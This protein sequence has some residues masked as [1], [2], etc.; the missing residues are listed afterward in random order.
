MEVG[1]VSLDRALMRALLF[2]IA[3]LVV[4]CSKPSDAPLVGAS[5]PALLVPNWYVDPANASGCASDANN[6]QSATCGASGVGPLLDLATIVARWGTRTPVLTG[7]VTITIVSDVPA[8]DPWT[9]TPTHAGG[10]LR[11]QGVPSVVATATLG[12]YVAA[13]YAAGTKPTITAQAQTG[14]YWAPYVNAIAHDTTANA[15]FVIDADLGGATASV[16]TAFAIPLTTM[17]TPVTPAGGDVVQVLHLPTISVATLDGVN[18]G[19]SITPIPGL[20]VS[21]LTI[22]PVNFFFAIGHSV[23]LLEDVITATGFTAV[24]STGLLSEVVGCSMGTTIFQGGSALFYG[25]VMQS[26]GN[27]FSDNSQL[28]GDVYVN[29]RIHWGSGNILLRQVYFGQGPD[30][31]AVGATLFEVL[32]SN[33]GGPARAWGPGAVNIVAGNALALDTVTATAALLVTGGVQVDGASTA[34]PWV[35]ASHAYGAAVAVTPAAIDAAGGLSNPTT[36]SRI[37]RR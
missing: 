3:C 37:F 1:R 23:F 25:G 8:S 28:D 14:A 20:Q 2:A 5:S 36:G 34:F 26:A 6:G 27:F 4:S 18:L 12:T 19:S 29:Q 17:P 15:T 24:P 33:G 30:V 7:A 10:G 32:Q 16:T 21:E 31:D 9:V 13:N 22:E 11:L 35:G